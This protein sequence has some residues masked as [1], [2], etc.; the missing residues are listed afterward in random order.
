M[1]RRPG[2]K[3]ETARWL[4]E[5]FGLRELRPEQDTVVHSLLAGKRVLFVA[6][7][8]HGKSLS[9]AA[10]VLREAGAARPT[11]HVLTMARNRHTDDS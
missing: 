2:N 5:R 8:G 9:E 11:I 3:E 4:R 7:T 10:K 1:A 6:P